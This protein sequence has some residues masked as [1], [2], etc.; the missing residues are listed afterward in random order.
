RRAT[1]GG[2][3]EEDLR[4]AHAFAVRFDEPVPTEEREIVGEG[5]RGRFDL[6]LLPEVFARDLR[7]RYLDEGLEHPPLPGFQ[8][9]HPSADDLLVRR[10]DRLDMA[11]VVQARGRDAEVVASLL[12]KTR[13]P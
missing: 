4:G 1:I 6:G 2:S 5:P 10:G 8:L 12:D 9:R 7:R 3:W 11:H 13:R